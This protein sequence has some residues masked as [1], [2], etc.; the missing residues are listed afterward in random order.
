M[1]ILAIGAHPDDIELG[2]EGTLNK[3]SVDHKI[4]RYV[5]GKG[6][7]DE[8]DNMFD[9]KPLLFWIQEIEKVVQEFNPDRIYTHHAKDQNIDHRIVHEA[10][11]TACRPFSNRIKEIFTYEVVSS[12]DV[13]ETTFKPNYYETLSLGDVV[14]KTEKLRIEYDRE[15][16]DWPHPRSGDGI[17]IKIKQR[18]M[19]CGTEYAEAFEVLRIIQW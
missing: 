1:K 18:G 11:L 3:L 4:K 7:G 10:T 14:A 17:R 12:T 9:K 19:E 16:R 2:C 13:S 5:V 6:R 8:L 15:M